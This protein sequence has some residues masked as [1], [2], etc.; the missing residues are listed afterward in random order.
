MEVKENQPRRQKDSKER[1]REIISLVGAGYRLCA[2]RGKRNLRH[3][4]RKEGSKGKPA[5]KAERLEGAQRKIFFLPWCRLPS[6][7]LAAKRNL[8]TNAKRKKSR[9]EFISFI[10][11][12]YRH[13]ALVIKGATKTERRE[14]ARRRI[15]FFPRFT[16]RH[17]A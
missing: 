6:W 1:K 7:G 15:Y 10:G 2:S 9:K 5:T 14:R 13:C 17:C 16:Y 3:E 11:V 4:D 8:T 12:T